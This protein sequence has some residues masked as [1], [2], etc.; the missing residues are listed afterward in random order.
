MIEN[1]LTCL[2]IKTFEIILC[3]DTSW[4]IHARLGTFITP[5]YENCLK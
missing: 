5:I 3:D 1:R 2:K 4:H